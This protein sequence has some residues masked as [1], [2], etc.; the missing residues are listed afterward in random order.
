MIVQGNVWV[1]ARELERHAF[2]H[3]CRVRQHVGLMGDSQM[4][5][6]A[7]CHFEASSDD[8][9]HGIAGKNTNYKGAVSRRHDLADAKEHVS[10]GIKTLGVLA[11]Y[12]QVRVA[13]HSGYAWNIFRRADIRI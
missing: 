13:D 7:S 3:P 1:L 6:S 4:L 10:I 9:S 12:H 5:A 11:Q 2:K 8:A